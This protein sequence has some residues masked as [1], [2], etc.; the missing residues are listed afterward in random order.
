MILTLIKLPTVRF[1]ILSGTHFFY[2]RIR[3]YLALTSIVWQLVYGHVELSEIVEIDDIF[4]VD[5]DEGEGNVDILL[6]DCLEHCGHQFT[7]VLL[8]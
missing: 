7:Q 3:L 4:L 5:V 2:K 6:S 1:I 8:V